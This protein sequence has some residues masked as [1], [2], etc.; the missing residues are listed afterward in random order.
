[1]PGNEIAC[2]TTRSG[3]GEGIDH[4]D[5]QIHRS[6]DPQGRKTIAPSEGPT[7]GPLAR[8]AVQPKVAELPFKILETIRLQGIRAKPKRTVRYY[9]SEIVAGPSV[10]GTN[11]FASNP[12]GVSMRFLANVPGG[13][14]K[15]TPPPKPEKIGIVRSDLS[16]G[17][18]NARPGPCLMRHFDQFGLRLDVYLWFSASGQ[19]HVRG[20]AAVAL[21]RIHDLC[22]TIGG[23]SRSS[24]YLTITAIGRALVGRKTSRS[25]FRR[26]S[27]ALLTAGWALPVMELSHRQLRPASGRPLGTK[28]T[29][30]HPAADQNDSG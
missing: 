24:Q 19:W 20:L 21:C 17:E 26:H 12:A 2:S 11:Q 30:C 28:E 3:R 18:R 9:A 22:F 6:G 27:P 4:L 15:R 23:P 10:R 7:F 13:K 1:L 8:F 5:S 25:D 14:Y 16:A 29:R